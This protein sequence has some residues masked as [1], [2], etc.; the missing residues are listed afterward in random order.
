[1]PRVNPPQRPGNGS[2][3]SEILSRRSGH[4]APESTVALGSGVFKVTEEAPVSSLF[5]ANRYAGRP[6]RLGEYLHVSDLVNKCTR[7][8][9]LIE[10]MKLTPPV[11]GLSL[12][13]AL[14]FAQGDAVHDAL[15]D[16]LVKSA[17]DRAYGRWGCR[18]GTTVTDKPGIFSAV[19]ATM[20]CPA[21]KGTL[22]VYHELT[23]RDEDHKITGSPDFLLYSPTNNFLLVTEI[24]S[25]SHDMWKDLARPIPEHVLQ[26][27]FYWYLLSRAGYR[28]ADK[29][30][31]LYATKSY[32]FRGSPIKEMLV[33][34]P[35]LMDSGRLTTYIAYADAVKAARHGGALPDRPCA[36]PEQT[37]AKNCDVCVQCFGVSDNVSSPTKISFREAT[38][39]TPSKES[40]GARPVTE[41]HRGRVLRRR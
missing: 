22:N 16:R 2:R 3:L 5:D 10:R 23:V 7:R 20:V 24:K 33:D 17:P 37:N 11:R 39:R 35:A 34:M 1:M 41:Q 13:D 4:A 9:A 15:R 26:V 18:C 30:S 32:V 31:I 38:T 14:T 6:P 40:D 36:S 28:L 29:A 25:M 12:S 19:P 8:I 21:C 27:A